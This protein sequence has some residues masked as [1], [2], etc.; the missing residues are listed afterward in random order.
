MQMLGINQLFRIE[1]GDGD[2]GVT[3]YTLNLR[4]PL[5]SPQRF[6]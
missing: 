5:R 4:C 3:V 2:A 1:Y 6:A